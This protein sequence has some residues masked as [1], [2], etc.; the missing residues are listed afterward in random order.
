MPAIPRT[1]LRHP[2]ELDQPVAMFRMAELVLRRWRVNVGRVWAVD[3]D[4]IAFTDSQGR[5]RTAMLTGDVE[6]EPR[7][8]GVCLGWPV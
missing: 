6:G 1:R 7:V 4:R 3:V 8:S 5:A 2:A